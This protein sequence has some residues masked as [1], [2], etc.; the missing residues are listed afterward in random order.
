MPKLIL[1]VGTS[2]C[3]KT[4][5]AEDYISRNPN[6]VMLSRDDYRFNDNVTCWDDYNKDRREH[7]I[8]FQIMHDFL[9]LLHAGKD[10]LV[11]DTNLT[12]VAREQWIDRAYTQGMDLEIVIFKSFVDKLVSDPY[13]AMSL[14]D[15]VLKHQY[16]RFN[17]FLEEE[18]I[19]GV[20]YTIV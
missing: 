12:W 20:T 2:F 8:S 5:W 3:G 1:T 9:K 6:T 4:S 11:C 16:Q 13:L 15:Y 14:P 17:K 19:P 18:T 7:E 10:I